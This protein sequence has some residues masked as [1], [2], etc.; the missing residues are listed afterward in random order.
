MPPSCDSKLGD[1][2][3]VLSLRQDENPMYDHSNTY[4]LK[5]NK[6]KKMKMTPGDKGGQAFLK[7]KDVI[8]S[9]CIKGE[10]PWSKFPEC[11][12]KINEA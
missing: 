4:R 9:Y 1:S 2:Q 6:V 5:M 12:Q 7:A 10:S 3:L 11:K 8:F